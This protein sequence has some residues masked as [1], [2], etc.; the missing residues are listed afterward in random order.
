MHFFKH[1]FL[2]LF[3]LPFHLFSTYCIPDCDIPTDY[4][5]QVRFG[6]YDVCSRNLRKIYSNGWFDYQVEAGKRVLPNWEMWANVS[7]AC[8]HGHVYSSYGSV[9]YDFRNNTRMYVLPVA[10]GVKYVYSLL[11]FV[12]VYAGAG[13]CYSFLKIK[14]FCKQKYSYWD[15]SE[16]PFKKS[17]RT[18][19]WGGVIK[20]GAQYALS[21]YTFIDIYV[22]YYMQ[23]FTLSHN[24]PRN[25]LGSDIDVSGFK[26]GVGI[27]VY[28]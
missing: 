23:R 8:K 25:V 6:S 16:S 4:T 7:W 2:C 22:D 21:T 27:G 1:I 12:D 19:D 20:V 5:L 15:L 17:L 26:Y 18:S 13:V 11:P 14:N 3:L 24:D 9:D 10:L 28:F